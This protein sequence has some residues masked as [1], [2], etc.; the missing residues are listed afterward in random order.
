VESLLDKPW[1]CY[2]YTLQ[3]GRPRGRLA[4]VQYQSLEHLLIELSFLF[5]VRAG[6]CSDSLLLRY[7]LFHFR[8]QLRRRSAHKE[9]VRDSF[10]HQNRADVSLALQVDSII[11]LLDM[12]GVEYGL[13]EGQCLGCLDLERLILSLLQVLVLSGIPPG[14]AN[15]IGLGIVV[16]M[17]NSHNAIEALLYI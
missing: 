6:G 11:K 9:Q 12:H 10:L 4:E 13:D 3:L 16:K 1:R 2:D 7:S 15:D 17:L 14:D 8:L 5:V